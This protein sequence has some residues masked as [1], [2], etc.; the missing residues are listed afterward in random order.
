VVLRVVAVV[1]SWRACVAQ[2]AS[3]L[4]PSRKSADEA[5]GSATITT[6]ELCSGPAAVR[7]RRAS[8]IRS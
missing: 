2:S 5:T 7:I 1:T 8:A 6:S 3:A 4:R